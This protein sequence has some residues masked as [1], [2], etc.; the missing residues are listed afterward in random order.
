VQQQTQQQV[1]KQQQQD[2]VLAQDQT[3]P[4]HFIAGVN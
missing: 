2:R 4:I 1:V 3:I